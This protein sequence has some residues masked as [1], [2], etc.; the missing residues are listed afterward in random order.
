V[1]EFS[2]PLSALMSIET[3]GAVVSKDKNDF[4]GIK[5]VNVVVSSVGWRAIATDKYVAGEV[6]GDFLGNDGLGDDVVSFCVEPSLLKMVVS[7]VKVS[8][9]F[10]DFRGDVGGF[11]LGLR[12]DGGVLVSVD[13]CFGDVDV[14]VDV[15]P[16]FDKARR[17]LADFSDCDDSSGSN[18]AGY[19]V[20]PMVALAKFGKVKTSDEVLRRGVDPAKAVVFYPSKSFSDSFGG[21]GSPSGLLHVFFAETKA[22]RG[23]VSVFRGAMVS[24]SLKVLG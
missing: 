6:S 18:L 3:L 9:V 4:V 7:A 22:N 5:K 14:D 8:R 13:G 11:D 21:V 20:L 17:L 1:K 15:S 19:F 12:L 2:L 16:I 10:R 23:D 24:R